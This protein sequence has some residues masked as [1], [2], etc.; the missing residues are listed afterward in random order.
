MSSKER[1]SPQRHGVNYSQARIEEPFGPSFDPPTDVDN[2]GVSG[3]N[4]IDST[5]LPNLP[6]GCQVI[7]LDE[8]GPYDSD[9]EELETAPPA[10]QHEQHVQIKQEFP[11]RG[12]TSS[13]PVKI[14]IFD[15]DWRWTDMGDQIIDLTEADHEDNN[16][17]DRPNAMSDSQLSIMN[18]DLGQSF[19]QKPSGKPK[20]SQAAIKEAQKKY[21]ERI[22]K[23]PVATGASSIFGG[24]T[25]SSSGP[26]TAG[27]LVFPVDPDIAAA[28]HFE[29]AKEV[30]RRK[31]LLGE[32]SFQDD[33]MWGKAK[34]AEKSRIK[35]AEEGVSLSCGIDFSS[36]EAAES[37][38]GLFLPRN[39]SPKSSRKRA[40]TEIVDDSDYDVDEIQTSST[41][42]ERDVVDILGS[43]GETSIPVKKKAPSKRQAAKARELDQNESRMAGIQDYLIS[44][45]RKE[46][47]GAKTARPR[48]T[49]RSIKGRKGKSAKGKN[50]LHERGKPVRPGQPGYLLNSSSLLSSNIYDEANDNLNAAPA[51]QVRETRKDKALK[52]MLIDIPLEDLKR[53]RSEKQSILQSTKV[54]G[55]HGRCYYAND[56]TGKWGLK[57]MSTTLYSHQIQGAAWMKLRE[58]GDVAPYG[59]ILADQM[60]LG[61]TLMILACM[62]SNPPEPVN[63]SKATL[64]VCPAS[65]V[66]QWEQEIERHT[67]RGTFPVVLRQRCGERMGGSSGIHLMFG[68]ADVVVTT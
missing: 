60:G 56:G 45:A 25:A 8:Y 66:H 9:L 15:D 14:E 55:K 61:K 20:L 19:L 40:H 58:E 12:G 59:G 33:V 23:R 17:Q 4:I 42:P 36:D 28:T 10:M 24:G 22:T 30:Y 5:M 50:I 2:P 29:K 3:E 44:E 1:D 63:S 27:F 11:A 52:A 38:E 16:I 37:D 64:I 6:I 49:A 21:A 41:A 53:A 26:L 34:A 47:K 67:Q 48:K 31:V 51:P 35:H 68:K 62:V 46:R 7:D 39:T 65:L 57:G 18:L 32:N 54:L 13:P 43:E